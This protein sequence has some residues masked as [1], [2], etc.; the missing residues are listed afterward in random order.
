MTMG[1]FERFL[2]TS[3]KTRSKIHDLGSPHRGACVWM[4]V[5]GQPK[6]KHGAVIGDFEVYRQESDGQRELAGFDLIFDEMRDYLLNFEYSYRVLCPD[7]KIVVS[8]PELWDEVREGLTADSRFEWDPDRPA[9]VKGRDDA[10]LGGRHFRTLSEWTPEFLE[11]R[12]QGLYTAQ[13]W[14]QEFFD[15][16]GLPLEL[17]AADFEAF[18]QA[19]VSVDS[20][21]ITQRMATPGSH[22]SATYVLGEDGA[23]RALEEAGLAGKYPSFND[24]SNWTFIDTP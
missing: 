23:R 6:E 16:D 21:L 2:G 10:D 18:C 3:K 20:Q 7:S 15:R 19:V 14:A 4:V 8:T 9:V 24:V 5:H 13:D 11:A 17:L 22:A 1:I 12:N